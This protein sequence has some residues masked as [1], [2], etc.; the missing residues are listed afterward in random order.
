[1][2]GPIDFVIG[3]T[4]PGFP[5]L[6][7]F[8]FPVNTPDRQGPYPLRLSI[9]D[10][11]EIVSAVLRYRVSGSGFLPVNMTNESGNV[12]SAQIPGAPAGATVDYQIVATDND[13]NVTVFPPDEE[14]P[15]S[16]NVISLTGEPLIYVVMSESSVLSVLDSGSGREV[17]RIEMGDTP[18]SA[19]I[20][21]DEEVIF[22]AN[23]GFGA[24]TSR[25][26]SAISTLTH[27][28]LA[29]INV[30]FGPLDLTMSSAGDR[31]FA[32]NSDS[33]SLS[34]IDVDGLRE[35][36]RI[37]LPGL[38]DGPFGVAVSPDGQTVYATDI[39]SNQVF[40]V[41]TEL[42]NVTGQI[43]VVP[44]PRS[45]AVSPDGGTLYVSG[46]EGGIGVVDLSQG[47][48]VE[49][50]TTPGGVFRVA[51][52]PDGSTLYATDQDGN[53]LLVIDTE[54]R[55][56]VR[57]LN[58][59]PNGSNTRGLAVSP[60][61]SSIYVTNA[62]SNDLVVFDSE[63]LSIVSTYNLGEGPRGIVV[64][65]RPFGTSLPTTTV[66][67][68]DFDADGF[69]GFSDF[70]LFAQAF[71]RNSSDPAFDPRFDLDGNGSIDFVDFLSFAQSFGQ[72]ALN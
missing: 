2:T 71:G 13:G 12:W 22:V 26:V 20:T 19:V 28:R 46:F 23:T 41:N 1:V 39:G 61:G 59:L 44:S 68:S 4:V 14:T 24:Q 25:T 72:S 37:N 55:T 43:S 33:R 35:V 40:V 69:V 51:L 45:L 5:Q 31:V 65:S 56:L 66:A 52:S 57:T 50:I 16:F 64:R 38:V 62:N 30:G 8:Q 67:L 9:S 42:K 29:T 34:V 18:H 7:N 53:N 49:R 3:L 58:V 11:G 6:T 32:S 27:A 48:E 10:E 54:S 36:S 60:D 21:P 15:L 63:S 17:A 70:L 47:R